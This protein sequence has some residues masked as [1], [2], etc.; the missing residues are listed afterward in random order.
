MPTLGISFC[1][2]ADHYD[3]ALFLHVRYDDYYL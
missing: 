3:V 2:F 1:K